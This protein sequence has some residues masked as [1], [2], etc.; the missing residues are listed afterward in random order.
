[1]SG[2]SGI[3]KSRLLSEVRTL[4]LISGASVASGQAVAEGGRSFHI[5]LP[6]LRTLCL[7]V[8]LPDAEASALKPLAP[9]LPELL[10]RAIPDAAPLRPTA[11]LTRLFNAV[12]VLLRLQDRTTVILLEDLQWA[13]VDSIELLAHL[14]R[15]VGD[16]RTVII[17]SYRSDEAPLLAQ[18]V[19][20]AS[21]LKLGPLDKEAC[22]QLTTSMSETL[23]NE[24]ALV[25]YLYAQSEGNVY[26]LIEILR[27]LANRAGQLD[28]IG[29]AQRPER[30]LTGG[31]ARVVRRRI[32]QVPAGD[33]DLLTL[34]ATAGREIDFKALRQ[35]AAHVDMDR[36]L[37]TCVNACI[38]ER[39]AE[40]W[41][42][43]HDKVRE[44]VL[45]GMSPAERV[46]SHAQVARALEAAYAGSAREGK[47][48]VLAHHCE[49]AGET[50]KA[51]AYYLQAGDMATRQ[52]AYGESRQHYASALRLADRGA[53]TDA[54]KRHHIDALLKLAYTCFVRDSAEEN[55]GRIR[56]ARA[57]LAEIADEPKLVPED[58]LRLARMECAMGR[59]HFYR[60][61]IAPA[62][63]HYKRVLP[64]A[65][66]SGDQE[67]LALPACLIGTALLTQGQARAAE[68]LLARAV[69]PLEH[70]GE[71]FEW[72]RAAGYHGASLIA[73]GRYK[74]G[75]AQLDI[76]LARAK[77]IG[78]SSMLSAA[79]LMRGCSYLLSGDWPLVIDNLTE[80]LD[81]ASQSGDKLHMSL[82]WSGIG[83]A[84]SHLGSIDNARICRRKG[85]GIAQ[86]LGGQLMLAD[87]FAAGD[88]EM[89]L[90]AGELELAMQRAR[91]IVDQSRVAGRLFSWGVGERVLGEVMAYYARFSEADEHMRRSIATLEEGGLVLHAE[92]SRAPWGIQQRARG[93]EDESRPLLTNA[94]ERLESFGCM[95]SL[96]QVERW[97][98][99]IG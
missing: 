70:L 3:G 14:S 60:G 46:T 84:R 89:A 85:A 41:H 9:E 28:L 18:S 35:L 97:E 36:W 47:S 96:A 22:M 77:Q 80:V 40:H 51:A 17:G 52:C 6:V 53:M 19:P 26:F 65:E 30:F 12:T 95:F 61:D 42:F 99:Q 31:I 54:T 34:A 73:T 68:A 69:E 33:R 13:D 59:I 20:A 87:W 71:P 16:M 50:Q 92:L 67:L 58:Q 55:F 2:E 72:F 15:V 64:I 24:P 94:K 25:D 43:A 62:I 45:N 57:L 27:E 76:V 37:T 75:V 7:R 21:L 56:R 86:A 79:Y 81:L 8:D 29:E 90:H 74:E 10:C 4:G 66:A 63:E 1:V 38:L 11:A 44:A 78:Q 98:A 39:D 93:S 88:A 32:E 83:W 91:E 49:E 82:A 48:A 5:W 23:K